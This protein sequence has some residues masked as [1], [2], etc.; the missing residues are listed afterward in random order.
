M[1]WSIPL[2][3]SLKPWNDQN[4]HPQSTVSSLLRRY[5]KDFKFGERALLPPPLVDILVII[6]RFYSAIIKLVA[7]SWISLPKLSTLP[8]S[9]E[10]FW[11]DGLWF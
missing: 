4:L 10:L 7:K 6:W 11:I 1:I 9:R 3:F 2:N 5:Q 8:L